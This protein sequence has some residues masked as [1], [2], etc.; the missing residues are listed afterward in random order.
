MAGLQGGKS[1]GSEEWGWGDCS[2]QKLVA[3]GR[4]NKTVNLR[5]KMNSFVLL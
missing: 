3:K 5:C 2:F 4:K 1:M